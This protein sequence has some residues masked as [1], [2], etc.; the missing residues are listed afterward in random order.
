MYRGKKTEKSWGRLT[1]AM[2][3]ILFEVLPTYY[4]TDNNEYGT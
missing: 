1:L 2:P 4:K 3:M